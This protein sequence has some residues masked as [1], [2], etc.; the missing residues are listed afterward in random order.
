ML[1]SK[2]R[3]IIIIVKTPTTTQ[4]NLNLGWV[5]HENDFAYPT[6]PTTHPTQTQYQQYLSCYWPY[7]NQTL[8][9]G[10]WDEQQQQQ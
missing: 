5:R 10:F 3:K 2:I 4:L 6:P 1:K 8:K 9:L 7:F